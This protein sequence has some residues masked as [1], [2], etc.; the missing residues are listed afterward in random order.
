M[1]DLIL[2]W[3]HIVGFIICQILAIYFFLGGLI[4]IL[5]CPYKIDLLDDDY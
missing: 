5:G 2:T 3:F 1:N 4:L